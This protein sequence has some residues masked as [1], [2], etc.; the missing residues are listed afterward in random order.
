[1]QIPS[2]SDSRF[3]FIQA[4]S[5]MPRMEPKEKPEVEVVVMDSLQPGT[6]VIRIEI[7]R[8]KEKEFVKTVEKALNVKAEIRHADF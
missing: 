8:E 3:P 5:I 4:H 6:R 7:P 1:M 2:S